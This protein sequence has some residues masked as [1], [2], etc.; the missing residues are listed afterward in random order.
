MQD[1][2]II[3]VQDLHKSFGDNVVLRGVNLDVKKGETIV[4]VGRSGTG[5]SVFLKSIIGLMQP[6]KGCI[7]VKGQDIT[8]LN[9]QEMNKI[10]RLFGMLFQEAALFDSMNVWEN[11]AFSLLE[12]TRI[13]MAQIDHIVKKKLHL[14]GLSGVE[15]K[16]P[17]ELSGGMKKRVGLARAIIMEPEIILYDEPTTGLDP[18]MAD[19]INKLIIDMQKRLSVTSVVISHD[20]NG[21]FKIA[22]RIAMLY[23][24]KIIEIGT[25]DDIKNTANPVVKQFIE[26]T[27]EGPIHV[28]H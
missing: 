18:I 27:V 24:G 9:L 8:K 13:D 10:R 22:N 12:H 3:A 20:I 16:M 17:A 25:P 28:D 19:V 7:S 23:G 1:Q 15:S 6:D 2:I 26:G 21:A 11:V 14:V 5:K 4:V